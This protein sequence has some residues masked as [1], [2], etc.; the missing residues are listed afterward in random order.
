ME[1]GNKALIVDDSADILTYVMKYDSE[2]LEI[3][4]FQKENIF[5]GE[6]YRSY[7]FNIE[8]T[9]RLI[10]EVP[11]AAILLDGDLRLRLKRF[12]G[13]VSDG[14]VIAKRIRQGIYGSLN[15]K[16][17]IY[18]ISNSFGM[19]SGDILVDELPKPNNEKDIEYILT[20][21]GMS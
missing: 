16:T 5:D 15:I 19:F 11:Y 10:T 2:Q 21:L 6:V 9:E 1:E 14:D 4:G 12:F 17:P 18:G 13:E 20:Q 3:G 7:Y 8:E